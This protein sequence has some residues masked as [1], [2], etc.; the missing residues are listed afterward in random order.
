M[1]LL[2][3]GSVKLDQI[4][5]GTPNSPVSLLNKS[6]ICSTG[7]TPKV[8]ENLSYTTFTID[9]DNALTLTPIPKPSAKINQNYCNEPKY[10]KIEFTPR[11]TPGLDR[12]SGTHRSES[13]TEEKS[14]IVVMQH[15][16]EKPKI[17]LQIKENEK[18][19]YNNYEVFVPKA[20]TTYEEYI[21][22]INVYTDANRPE[23]RCSLK[24]PSSFK[25]TK[26]EKKQNTVI[27]ER[28]IPV[29]KLIDTFEH[30]NR[31][32]MRY[33]QL[34]ESIPLSEGIKHLHDDLPPSSI[35]DNLEDEYEPTD[36]CHEGEFYT[37]NTAVETRSFIYETQEQLDTVD[38][39]K[40][41]HV[42]GSEYADKSGIT[43]KSEYGDRSEYT[44][45]IS[46][47]FDLRVDTKF[48]TIRQLATPDSLES[49]MLFAQK[50]S[51]FEDRRRE[52]HNSY[53]VPPKPGKIKYKY[54][55][56]SCMHVREVDQLQIL[57]T[58][59]CT[60]NACVS[61]ISWCITVFFAIPVTIL[62]I[63]KCI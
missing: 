49:S 7:L 35:D 38:E 62:L 31:P 12:M 53:N 24:S 21:P 32:V 16:I 45:E 58:K 18:S 25:A 37:A 20:H 39:N 34:E 19:K 17:E 50:Q 63:Y 14:N 56:V 36:T 9:K 33:L 11:S 48:Q 44:D 22:N 28:S 61:L 4:F 1:L 52:Y 5:R 30:N 26:Q 43:D 10:H 60:L 47:P 27:H 8:S 23:S 40:T 59:S 57:K 54:V 15:E 3:I 13:V 6:S 41:E 42:N 55:T 51:I 2:L 46:L 29:K